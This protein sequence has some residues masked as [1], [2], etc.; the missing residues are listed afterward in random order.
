MKRIYPL[1]VFA[2]FISCASLTP[3]GKMDERKLADDKD[4]ILTDLRTSAF[5]GD[6]ERVVR[7]GRR[8]LSDS[9]DSERAAEVRILMAESLLELEDNEG[10]RSTVRPVIEGGYGESLKADALFKRARADTADGLYKEAIRDLFEMSGMT[11]E[12]AELSRAEKMIR[13]IGGVLNESGLS[14]LIE[15]YPDSPLT[16][17]LIESHI[18]AGVKSKDERFRKILEEMTESSRMDTTGAVESDQSYYSELT[19]TFRIGVL[20]PLSGRFAPLGEAFVQGAYVA[21]KEAMGRG[22]KRIELVVADTE[23][24]PLEA[25]AVTKRLIREAGVNAIVGAISSASTIAA[26]EVAQFNRTVMFSPVASERGISEIGDHIFQEPGNEEVELIAAA[27]VAC[28]NLGLHR[29][30]FLAPN[31]PYYR[32]IKMLFAGEVEREGGEVVIADYYE[33]G[34]TDFRKNV[35][36]LKAA[37]PEALFIPADEDDLV[38][39]LPQLSFYEFGVQLLGL[40]EWDSDNLIHMA[41]KDISG[42]VFPAEMQPARDREIY[43][44]AASL[45]GEPGEEANRFEVEGYRGAKRI[46]SLLTIRESAGRSLRDLMEGALNNRFHPYIERYSAAGIPF[47]T[48]RDGEKITFLVHRLSAGR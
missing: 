15:E 41:Q 22:M 19:D 20:C 3:P 11:I 47:Y 18:A 17:A 39:I 30:A 14:G 2:L 12:K 26:A 10:A 46:I 40:S 24:K 6:H 29:I 8:Y 21:L 36:R 34:E 33:E 35:I 38:L 42:A 37:A 25:Q 43:V 45:V 16:S 48:V 13:A 44:E 23:A 5:E 27:K 32:R 28:G 9:A 1:L 7:T 4:E 31:K